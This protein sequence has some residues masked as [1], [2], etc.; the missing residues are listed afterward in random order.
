VAGL[1]FGAALWAASDELL[2]WVLRLAAPPWRYPPSTHLR[3]LGAHLTY[4]LSTEG[5]LRLAEAAF[6]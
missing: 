2:T 3:A 4:G 1:T 5:G 6:G